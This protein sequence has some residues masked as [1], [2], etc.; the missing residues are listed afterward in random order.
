[1]NGNT[2]KTGIKSVPGRQLFKVSNRNT[3]TRSE[4]YS[5]LTIKTPER[6]HWRRP[7]VF[8]VNFEHVNK[9][10]THNKHPEKDNTGKG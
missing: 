9:Q 8:I 10:K 4:L 1:M 5:K 2:V 6:G 7:G 3:S